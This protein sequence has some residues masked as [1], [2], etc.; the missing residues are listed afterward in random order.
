MTDELQKR[1]SE[2]LNS[3]A[4]TITDPGLVSDRIF[5]WLKRKL[6]ETLSWNEGYS[7]EERDKAVD[8]VDV[9]MKQIN[10]SDPLKSGTLNILSLD[11]TGIM[12]GVPLTFE[13]IELLKK[14]HQARIANES[15]QEN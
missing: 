10:I 1:L 6:P 11:S 7:K 9:E 2:K 4:D 13:D 8:A 15:V 5:S 3:E 14:E 12:A